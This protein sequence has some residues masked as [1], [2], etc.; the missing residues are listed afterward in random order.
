MTAGATPEERETKLTV[1]DD[2][3]MPGLDALPGVTADD[4]G[5]RQLDAV[6]WDSD[7]LRLAHAGVGLRHRNG[8]WTFKGRSRR[9][10]DA[11][12]R[13]EIE[14]AARGDA[15]PVP[16]SA[17]VA[18]CCDPASLH[19]VA[20]VRTRR[21]T[22]RVSRGG[23]SA[24]VVHDRAVVHSADGAAVH[25]FTEVEVEADAAGA[26]LA[27]AVAALLVARGA[28]VDTTP[29]YI[30]ALRALGYDPPPVMDTSSG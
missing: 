9:D 17:R 26:G 21:H 19:P 5:E 1:A 6:Y 22:W 23:A 11:V 16:L 24:E 14:V 8:V 3:T 13:E 18:M 20:V 10:G 29:K 15:I 25:S 28:A 4:E 12:V 27:D 7:D 2:F 30:R